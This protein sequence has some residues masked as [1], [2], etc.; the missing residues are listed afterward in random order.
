MF[1][2]ETEPTLV[3]DGVV[4]L[5]TELVNWYLVEDGGRVTIV[6]AGA[7]KYR[8][9][10]DRGLALLSRRPADV[11]AVLLTHGHADH[12]G[13]A[14]PVRRELGVPVLVHRDDERLTTTGKRAGRN[15]A[16]LL[17]YLRY[18]HAWKL[19]GH[20][21]SSGFPKHVQEVT[22]FE[23]NAEVDVPGAP[24]A[25][26]TPGHTAG[27]AAFWLESRGALVMGDLLCTRNP[28]TGA[29]GPQLMPSAFNLSNSTILDSL[30]KVESLDAGVLLFGHG[31]PWTQGAG[32][33]VRRARE[34][35]PT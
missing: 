30:S 7:P 33:A 16:S 32:D 22:T 26:H 20:L 5:G 1:A 17:P 24:R 25:I 19:L 12:I 28:L 23:D 14:E 13:F 2:Q 31:E 34:T 27:H 18:G 6:D 11:A 8:P 29:R 4:R 15:E 10:L 21:L 35:R 9:Q 3:A